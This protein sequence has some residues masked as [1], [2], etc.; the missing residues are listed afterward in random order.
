MTIK[1]FIK[2]DLK[3]RI[4]S[5]ENLDGKLTLTGLSEH[6]A[7]S[8]T[9]VRQAVQDLVK[10]Q[11]L[12]RR[13]NGRLA[14]PGKAQHVEGQETRLREA[15]CNASSEQ[16][17]ASTASAEA[18]ITTEIIRRS[19]L[20]EAGFLRE[21]AAAEEFAV[22]RSVL[23]RVFSTL[24]GRGL[25][26]HVPRR[27]WRIR[28]YREADMLQYLDVRESLELKALSLAWDRL[29]PEKIAEF[30]AGN[31]TD[32]QDITQID[33]RLHQYW[34]ELSSNRYIVDFFQRHGSYYGALFDQAA[35]SHDVIREAA[36]EHCDILRAIAAGNQQ[37]AEEL[38]SAHIR[39]QRPKVGRMLK[40]LHGQSTSEDKAE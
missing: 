37:Q 25:L 6:Y 3:Q 16:N 26:E 17:P 11:Y 32:P 19:L 35:L 24:A 33:N 12:E 36:A 20:G 13:A 15:H 18:K 23:R 34:I 1:E 5:G 27:G 8:A 7:V 39:G 14:H 31:R 30:L 40:A 29:D 10:E 28:A 22:G 21:E 9:P 38:L 2:A 4:S